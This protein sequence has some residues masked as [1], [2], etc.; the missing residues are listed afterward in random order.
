MLKSIGLGIACLTL[1]ISGVTRASQVCVDSGK[2]GDDKCIK[3]DK[4][5]KSDVKTIDFCSDDGKKDGDS[6]CNK[7]TDKDGKSDCHDLKLSS[8]DKD[9]DKDYGKDGDKDG[10]KD[11]DGKDTCK[12]TVTWNDDHQHSLCDIGD[13]GHKDGCDLV[14]DGRSYDSCG[15]GDV[16]CSN[17]DPTDPKWVPSAVP[18][19]TSAAMGGLGVAGIMLLTALRSRR[20]FTA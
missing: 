8:C 6:S 10:K 13:K 9:G 15:K 17:P 20:S 7:D 5:C 11:H 14:T 18:V 3:I 4:D 16:G 2:Y 12:V 1:A 19:P